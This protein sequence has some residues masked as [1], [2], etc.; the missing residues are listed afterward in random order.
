MQSTG[1]LIYVVIVFV[2][3]WV[4]IIRPQQRRVRAH[5]D[6]VASLGVGERVVTI[7]GVHGVIRSL[8]ESTLTLRVA[9][10]VDLTVARSAIARRLSEEE[11][12]ESS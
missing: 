7:G 3:L 2:L 4:L 6:L 12:R 8:N 5:R 11:A 9:S 10:E 1:L